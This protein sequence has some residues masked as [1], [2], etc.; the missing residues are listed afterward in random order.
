MYLRH[1]IPTS[2]QPLCGRL[3]I[4]LVGTILR[5]TIQNPAT[6]SNPI[7][8]HGESRS[9]PRYYIY[10]A[11]TLQH[12]H[13]GPFVPIG[14]YWIYWSLLFSTHS[15]QGYQPDSLLLCLPNRL[16]SS[17]WTTRSWYFV[18]KLSLS[19]YFWMHQFSCDMH[20]PWHCNCTNIS[21]LIQ[22]ISTS[23]TLQ[24]WIP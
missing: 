20:L 18:S 9:L 14:I 3:R 4:F 13:L 17:H 19:K 7:L 15:K 11:E 21:W 8:F 6:R 2:C 1:P 5:G 24:G 16:H 10:L 12:Q 22:K 23:S